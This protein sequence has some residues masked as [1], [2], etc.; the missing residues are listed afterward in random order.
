MKDVRSGLVALLPALFLLSACASPTWHAR[1]EDEPASGDP[2][3]QAAR[4]DGVALAVL[5]VS[6]EGLDDDLLAFEVTATNGSSRDLELR[7]EDFE[8]RL[9]GGAS[10]RAT[11]AS[12]VLQGFGALDADPGDPALAG[13]PAGVDDAL[14]LDDALAQSGRGALLVDEAS[15]RRVVRVYR[16]PTRYGPTRYG[17][18]WYR[19]SWYGP[20]VGVTW[21][22][23]YPLTWY[24]ARPRYCWSCG[25]SVRAE[26]T[27]SYRSASPREAGDGFYGT[28]GGGFGD[29]LLAAALRDTVIPAGRDE[30][31]LLFF[32]VPRVDEGAYQLRWLPRRVMDAGSEEE[33]SVDF[34]LQ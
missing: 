6:I 12:R 27:P 1:R 7:V 30:T 29:P 15:R 25:P 16:G 11:A 19:P 2:R 8:L 22:H 18:T 17:P 24:H 32:R 33:L 20:G 28:S 34:T 31:G 23:P 9:P 5:P 3:A 10:V 26:R 14:V 21:Y 13:S 4:A